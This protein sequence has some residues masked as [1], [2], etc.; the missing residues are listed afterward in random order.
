MQLGLLGEHLVIQ[1]P[2]HAAQPGQDGVRRGQHHREHVPA[3]TGLDLH[4]RH[5]QVARD[6]DRADQHGGD[7]G[8]EQADHQRGAQRDEDQRPVD[9]DQRGHDRR[10]QDVAH[11]DDR[12]SLHEGDGPPAGG[13]PEQA[14]RRD[15]ADR[16]DHLGV[17]HRVEGQ[18]Q[19]QQQRQQPDQQGPTDQ[20]DREPLGLG[21]LLSH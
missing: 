6:E 14:P 8:Q 4:E 16:D 9:A 19:H 18:E 13:E 10:E 12:V 21:S 11:G 20:A 7:R 1:V 15:Q 2:G 17:L 5:E 3:L